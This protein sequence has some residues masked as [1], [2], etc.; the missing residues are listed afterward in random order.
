MVSL[1]AATIH[2]D[3][4]WPSIY[5]TSELNFQQKSRSTE[6]P[7]LH[8]PLSHTCSLS[9]CITNAGRICI[10]SDY[11]KSWLCMVSLA[12]ASI[13]VRHRIYLRNVVTP[14]DMVN[15]QSSIKSV[16]LPP[17][18]SLWPIIPNSKTKSHTSTQT[19]IPKPKTHNLFQAPKPPPPPQAIMQLLT[20]LTTLAFAASA[21]AVCASGPRQQ[22][23]ACGSE[24][25]NLK[26][27][28]LNNQHV[29][30]TAISLWL[31]ASWTAS[32]LSFINC[33]LY[34]L[35]TLASTIPFLSSAITEA[36]SKHLDIQR[37]KYG[38]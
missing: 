9:Y 15:R 29:V 8:S 19:L 6:N 13:Q 3:L 25:T 32:S 7:D 21:L 37:H 11:T 17:F 35:S 16:H 20:V 33:T 12:T 1:A 18:F 27:C 24:C 26:R 2:Q 28:S 22:G 30:C 38:I 23:S 10:S 14:Y 36:S 34:V 5:Q 31:P 4:F